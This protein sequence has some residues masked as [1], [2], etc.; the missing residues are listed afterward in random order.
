MQSI[1]NGL[2]VR[3]VTWRWGFDLGGV[4]DFHTMTVS[5][6]ITNVSCMGARESPS[7]GRVTSS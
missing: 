4:S 2:V 1:G 5:G 6:R 7:A 3:V